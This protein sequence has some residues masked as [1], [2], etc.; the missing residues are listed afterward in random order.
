MMINFERNRKMGIQNASVQ[1]DVEI[2]ITL[3]VY[4][5]WKH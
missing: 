4:Q 3:S 1:Q 5:Q 2:V